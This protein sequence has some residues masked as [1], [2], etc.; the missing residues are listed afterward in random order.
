M[1]VTTPISPY[2]HI[3]AGRV[4]I[5]IPEI[6]GAPHQALTLEQHLRQDTGIHHVTANPQTGNVLILFDAK[7]LNHHDILVRIQ[8]SGYLCTPPATPL[9]ARTPWTYTVLQSAV[10]LA[11]EHL[12]LALI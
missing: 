2:L 4:R 12:V 10:E 7:A 6:K 8:G 9:P 5:K 11:L 3:L 1:P